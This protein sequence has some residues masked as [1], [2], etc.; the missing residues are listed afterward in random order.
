MLRTTGTKRYAGFIVGQSIISG[1]LHGKLNSVHLK[2]IGSKRI[3][4]K[5]HTCFYGTNTL[6]PP[7][8][9]EKGTI[10]ANF[11]LFFLY[12]QGTKGHLL[13]EVLK[14]QK[15]CLSKDHNVFSFVFE[16]EKSAITLWEI[17][18]YF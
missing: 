1:G 4:Q 14:T 3:Q 7:V 5:R 12:L 16:K 2:T 11:H 13:Q 17:L 10:G 9:F 8:F 6:L 15:H 18:C